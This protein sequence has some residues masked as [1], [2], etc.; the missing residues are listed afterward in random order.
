M[1]ILL[2]MFFLSSTF[3]LQTSYL[4]LKWQLFLLT[5]F[6]SVC[7]NKIFIFSILHIFYVCRIETLMVSN[8]M[9]QF[10]CSLINLQIELH[11]STTL[12]VDGN[13][14]NNGGDYRNSFSYLH[15]KLLAFK[16]CDHIYNCAGSYFT[17]M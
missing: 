6:L 9:S 10:P 3:S 15:A 16:S 13:V 17:K 14:L 5:K 8:K 11:F 4:K 1:K 2:I 12:S 7:Q